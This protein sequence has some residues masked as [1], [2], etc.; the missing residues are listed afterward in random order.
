P[1][2]RFQLSVFANLVATSAV[3]D[4]TDLIDRWFAAWAIPDRDT[5]ERAFESLA[6]PR[7]RFADRYSRLEGLDDLNGHVRAMQQFMPGSRLERRGAVRRS[8]WTLLAD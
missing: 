7:V 8:Q 3:G 6:A 1:G 2:W 4:A 5:R